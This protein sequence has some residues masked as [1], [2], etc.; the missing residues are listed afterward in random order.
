MN[1]IDFEVKKSKVKLDKGI[2]YLLN[3]L[4]ILGLKALKLGALLKGAVPRF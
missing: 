2:Y 4:I 1:P 3:I